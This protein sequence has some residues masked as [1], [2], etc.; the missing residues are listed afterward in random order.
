[1]RPEAPG[2]L[3]RFRDRTTPGMRLPGSYAANKVQLAEPVAAMP[4]SGL[5]FEKIQ[6]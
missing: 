3:A 4:P 2:R 1:M 6:G 5:A